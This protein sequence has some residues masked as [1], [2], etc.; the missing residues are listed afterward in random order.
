MS[1]FSRSGSSTFEKESRT[2]QCG[3]PLKVDDTDL[4]GVSVSSGTLRL[5]DL[6]DALFDEID[7]LDIEKRLPEELKQQG[8]ELAKYSAD[9]VE[10][11][12]PNLAEA[13]PEI[14]EELRQYLEDQAPDGW[15]LT[16]AEG[17]GAE[18]L[19]QPTTLWARLR[20]VNALT[21]EDIEQTTILGQVIDKFEDCPDYQPY[22]D[23][24]NEAEC[25]TADLLKRYDWNEKEILGA[26]EQYC[27]VC[28]IHW[29]ELLQNE[30]DHDPDNIKTVWV[31]IAYTEAMHQI[32]SILEGN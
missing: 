31:N 25:Y 22:S 4:W 3:D 30:T 15:T 12:P 24:M 14:V 27:G 19:W 17:D 32:E 18:L 7:R 23:W 9:T 28:G 29:T 6:A 20:A 26:V 2:S 11:L 5:S 8:S 21:I 10:D 16:T 1:Y 13:A